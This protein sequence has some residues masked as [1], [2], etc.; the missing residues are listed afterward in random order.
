MSYQTQTKP[1]V[2]FLEA[3]KLY[4]RNATNFSGRSRRSEYWMAVL[5]LLA[6]NLAG[7]FVM[8]LIIGLLG[9]V[10]SLIAGLVYLIWGVLCLVAS[11]S[12]CVRRLHDT[13][14]SGWWYLLSLV[15]F[16]SIVLLVWYCMDSTGDNQWGPNPKVVP[17]EQ[18]VYEE[19]TP[20]I[21]PALQPAPQPAPQPEPPAY[22]PTIFEPVPAPAPVAPPVP[23]PP[24]A[25]QLYG[26]LQLHTGPM[27]GKTFRF[28][29]G[30]T[31]TVGRNPSRCEVA[32]PSYAV[33]SGTHC[34]IAF[35][36]RTITI[37]DLN[38]TNGTFVNGIRLTPG[39]PVSVKEGATIQLANSTCAFKLRF[40]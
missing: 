28:P 24:P 31:V 20:V 12:L 23:V 30:R 4:V 40:E 26:V 21:A 22:E 38:S 13:G 34:K 27:A 14:R 10:G 15:P 3:G 36:K 6:V 2:G 33:V 1:S 19:F 7:S 16:G 35:G 25:P 39:K 37:V 17:F 11:L 29:E 8:G 5:F 9:D 32:L 18:S